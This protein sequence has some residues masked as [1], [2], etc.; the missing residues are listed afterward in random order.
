M[1]GFRKGLLTGAGGAVLAILLVIA[2]IVAF[3]LYDFSADTPHAS[4][5]RDLIAATRERAIARESA[6]IRVPRLDNPDRLREGA[7]HYDAMCT[8][9]HLAPD[10]RENE[11]RPG[12]NPK[13]PILAQLPPGDPRRQ[14]WIVKHGI[15]MTGMPAWGATHSDDEIWNMVA[16]LQRLPKLSP[17]DYRAL[18]ASA[19]GHHEHDMDMDH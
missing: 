14:F 12:M 8:G 15:K 1:T 9:C 16:L 19:G 5:T 6:S 18:V 3:G 11:M 4:L 7:E 10:L 13:P 17:K 2:A